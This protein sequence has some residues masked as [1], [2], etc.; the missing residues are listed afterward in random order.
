MKQRLA[1]A[2]AERDAAAAELDSA[3]QELQACGAPCRATYFCA[4]A[5]PSALRSRHA[6]RGTLLHRGSL[7]SLHDLQAK[8]GANVEEEELAAA[9]THELKEVRHCFV[10]SEL[11]FVRMCVEP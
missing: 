2:E 4:F 8:E 5:K 9:R 6:S 11:L 7:S 1:A 3:R 10:T